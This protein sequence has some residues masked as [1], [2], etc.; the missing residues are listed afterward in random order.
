MARGYGQ[1]CPV[2]KAAEILTERWTPL[3]VREL[4]AGSNRFNDLR[5][6]VPLMSP[7]LLSSRL[8]SLERAGVVER[9]PVD[10]GRGWEYHLTA[11]GRELEPIIELLGAWG[12]R[13]VTHDL[14]KEDLDPALLMWDI[15]R[16]VKPE[17]LPA[18][19]RVVVL[20][21]Y[22]GVPAKR[23]RW[24]LVFDRGEVDLCLTPPG[25]AVDVTVSSHIRTMT[26]VWLGHQELS[27]ALRSGDLTLQ[28]PAVLTRRFA[29]WIGLS[30]ST[31]GAAARS[32]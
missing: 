21:E 17:E 14:A 22:W 3:V 28:G 2:A 6:G 27:R 30:A 23:R 11:A 24:W 7:S 16:T 29:R 31:H 4:L 12:H 5:R 18:R 15:R 19:D 20:F 32:P 9:H 10:G 8:K 13:W 26:E 1:F 25:H